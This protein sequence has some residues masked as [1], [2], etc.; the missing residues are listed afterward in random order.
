MTCYYSAMEAFTV[1]DSESKNLLNHRSLPHLV[2]RPDQPRPWAPWFRSYLVVFH[3]PCFSQQH[4]ESVS[5]QVHVSPCPTLRPHSRYL[6]FWNS[7]S[8]GPEPTSNACIAFP[9][10]YPPMAYQVPMYVFL[11]WRMAKENSFQRAKNYK[12]SSNAPTGTYVYATHGLG[13]I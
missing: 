10:V 8:G 3:W 7:Q 9:W 12:Q 11:R 13:L 5:P 2:L 1:C 6:G 4:E